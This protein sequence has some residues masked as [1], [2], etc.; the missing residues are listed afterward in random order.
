M[1][2]I[3]TICLRLLSIGAFLALAGLAK[4]QNT[5]QSATQPAE[6]PHKVPAGFDMRGTARRSAGYVTKKSLEEMRMMFVKVDPNAILNL[7]A[8][9]LEPAVAEVKAVVAEAPATV[10]QPT[11]TELKLELKAQQNALNAAKLDLK[12]ATRAKDGERITE[13]KTNI[14]STQASISSIKK[15]IAALQ[16]KKAKAK[17]K[18]TSKTTSQPAK[19]T[20]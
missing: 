8:K 19:K 13:A 9:P 15:Q 5:T 10:R 1:N 7:D 17:K 18:A 6:V 11:V 4:A 16:P 12:A 3:M 14:K 2:R 20:A